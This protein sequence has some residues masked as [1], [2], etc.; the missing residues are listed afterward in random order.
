MNEEGQEITCVTF[1]NFTPV[2]EDQWSE[3]MCICDEKIHSVYGP[4]VS[5]D[6]LHVIKATVPEY[7]K[8]EEESAMPNADIFD[9]EGYNV[10]IASQVLLPKGNKHQ[11]GKIKSCKK[12]EQGNLIRHLD[13]NPILDTRLHEYAVNMIAENLYS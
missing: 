11:F 13:S 7:D 6:D 1:Q 2:E 5:N 10:L 3:E 12:D 4:G 8:I 9:M